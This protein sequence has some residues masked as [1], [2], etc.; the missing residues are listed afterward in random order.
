MFS[1]FLSTLFYISLSPISPVNFIL[2]SDGEAKS[3]QQ[4]S[5][6]T[7]P[8]CCNQLGIKSTFL[9]QC[10]FLFSS[11]F[12]P[13]VICFAC[14]A[15]AL[16]FT[17]LKAAAQPHPS[18]KLPIFSLLPLTFPS[19]PFPFNTGLKPTDSTVAAPLAL[20]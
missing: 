17:F 11:H 9:R 19:T 18:K 14:L 4:C 7:Q 20:L 15:A 1:F 12:L 10:I 8:S 2:Q 6:E 5:Q 16:N 13:S 3:P